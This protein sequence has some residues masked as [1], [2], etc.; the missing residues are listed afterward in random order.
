LLKKVTPGHYTFIFEATKK[1][2]KYIQ[3]SKIDKEVGLRFV[4]SVL[5]NKL[6]EIHDEVLVSTN[7][8]NSMLSLSED[9]N[10]PIYSY[11]VEENISNLIEMIIDPGEIE[12]VG[13][14]TI[15]DFSG[16]EGATL[17][18]EGAGDASFFS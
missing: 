9:S 4:P 1:I 7:I 6:I 17:V 5:I 10:E 11:Q 13:Q 18:R 2:S 12:F 14:S 15:I 3:A 16:S 8:P